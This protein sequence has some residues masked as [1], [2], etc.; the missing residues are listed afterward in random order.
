VRKKAQAGQPA[1]SLHPVAVPPS[2]RGWYSCRCRQ[3][4]GPSVVV[5]LRRAP[6]PAAGRVR[7]VPCAVCSS[8][9]HSTVSSYP[10]GTH[11]K[12]RL[13]D[14]KRTYKKHSPLYGVRYGNAMGG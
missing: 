12:M 9:I 13:V 7:R 10:T 3:P 14:I 11:R 2:P 8:R 5:A 4:A 6:P 1:A